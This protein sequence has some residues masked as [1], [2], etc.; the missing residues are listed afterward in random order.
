ML[1]LVPGFLSRITSFLEQ[2]LSVESLTR[3]LVRAGLPSL[4]CNLLE[5]SSN[6]TIESEFV[7][8]YFYLVLC[9]LMYLAGYTG[10]RL[11]CCVLLQLLFITAGPISKL[12]GWGKGRVGTRR[13]TWYFNT[14]CACFPC[15]F[16]LFITVGPITKL[17]AWGGESGGH[18]LCDT[19]SRG[20][21]G[22]V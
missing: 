1:T 6:G 4:W 3:Y 19:S 13:G 16:M 9:V 14:G 5:V 21:C 15:V 2:I 17:F 20:W 8:G 10:K 12:C 11:F 22:R 7:V 18:V